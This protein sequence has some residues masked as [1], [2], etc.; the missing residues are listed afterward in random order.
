ML[1]RWKPR[2]WLTAVAVVF[3]A[4][5]AASLGEP[6]AHAQGDDNDYVDVALTLDAPDAG[7]GQRSY[8]LNIIVENHGARTAY[9]VEVA[10]NVAYPENGSYLQ[11][12]EASVGSAA[13]D[14]RGLRWAIPELG[15]L[16]RAEIVTRVSHNSTSAP[17]FNNTSYS[18]EVFGDVTTSSFESN[19]HKGNNTDRIWSYAYH[20]RVN[21]V[22]FRQVAG[23]Y[24][25]AATVDNPSPSP[26]D[27]VNFT[28]SADRANPYSMGDHPPPI[29]LEVDIGLTDGL[30][31]SGTP[32][33]ASFDLDNQ[34]PPVITPATTPASVSYSNGVFNIG[35]LKSGEPTR[36]SVTL[37]VSVAND[38]VVN[39]QC[40]TATLTGNPP[41]GT[42]PYD[43]DISDN[44]A[45][46]CLGLPNEPVVFSSGRSDLL[47]LFPCVG[48]AVYPCDTTDSVELAVKGGTAAANVGSLYQVFQPENVVIHIG[49][50]AGRDAPSA[51]IRW[52]TGNDVDH[53]GSTGA[54]ILPGVAS[55][56][57]VPSDTDGDTS[58]YEYNQ[59]TFAIADGTPGDANNPGY[60]KF[61]L[62]S[63]NFLVVST[64]PA[65]NKAS[66]PPFNIVV[67]SYDI[68]FAFDRLGTYYAEM[69]FGANYTP[70]NPDTTYT[71]TATYAFHVGPI[72]ELGVRGGG[73]SSDATSDQVAFTVVA[74]NNQE[75]NTES[76]KVVVELPAGTTGLT[77]APA[78]TGVFD[79]T[80]KP[81]TWTWDISDLEYSDRRRSKRLPAGETVTLIV[82]GVSAGGTATANIV[83]DPYLVCIASD[84]STLA[85]ATQT[86]C[87]A[88]TGAS[89]HEGTV[90]DYNAGNDT[91]TITAQAGVRPREESPVEPEQLEP[92][93]EAE[94]D[95]TVVADETAQTPALNPDTTAQGEVT[96]PAAGQVTLEIREGEDRD[97]RAVN[98]DITAPDAPSADDPLVLTL[99]MVTDPDVSAAEVEVYWDEHDTG[100]YLPVP[101]CI[102]DAN[103]DPRPADPDPCVASREG[104]NGIVRIVV[105]TTSASQW[106]LLAPR[107]RAAPSGGGTRTVY[108]GGGTQVVEV[109]VRPEGPTGLKAAAK[110]ETEV[111]LDWDA[112]GLLYD[113][114]VD[115]YEV[116]AS[117]DGRYWRTLAPSVAETTYTHGG[118]EAGA[119]HYYRVYAHSEGGRSL[120]SAVACGSTDGA[121]GKP[122]ILSAKVDG[123]AVSLEWI[124]ATGADG[125][126]AVLMNLV[127]YDFHG[128]IVAIPAG[129]TSHTFEDVPPGRYVAIVLAYTGTVQDLDEYRYES[130]LITVGGSMPGVARPELGEG[131]P[132]WLDKLATSGR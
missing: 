55:K 2:I 78:N 100:D 33:Y 76:G 18:H 37:P 25:V 126:L 19:R 7:S 67:P 63:N 106:Q 23:N 27:T 64:D 117:E 35:T 86:A 48:E 30:S 44:V 45:K 17:I 71:D 121:L 82:D 93:T 111:E 57:V 32:T 15:G 97:R 110:G 49:D 43:D 28:I 122:C 113:A 132:S 118:L 53:S 125:H 104:D 51:G 1:T 72:A 130:A 83:Y 99:Q 85:H 60:V 58:V 21:S 105:L 131:Q 90:Y 9:D 47:T 115:Y 31:V 59:H 84:G 50:P 81:P 127:D 69:T 112:L 61:Y 11:D 14:G 87:E 95:V 94:V 108:V 102:S 52:L 62:A 116:E 124:N 103:A 88:V 3:A 128:D 40:L 109:L 54:G 36:N 80:V 129:T 96:T 12:V 29:D 39:E 42:G 123:S 6:V 74:V 46:V 8:V 114:P 26:G 120:A 98:F 4:F 24:S 101:D 41:P 38:A 77:T 73:A 13:R 107:D 34:S 16:Q 75:G 20:I 10:V 68:Y 70:D 65:D 66:F 22:E 92:I 5:A 79:G 91:A 119:T 89:W 56:L